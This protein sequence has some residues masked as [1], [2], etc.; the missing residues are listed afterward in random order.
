MSELPVLRFAPSPN[1]YLHLGHALSARVGRQLAQKLRGKFLVRIEDID[2]G[3]TREAFVSAIFEDLEWL[4][5][6]WDP[7]ILRQSQETPIYQRAAAHLHKLNLLYPCFATRS[8]IAITATAG[9]RD[10]QRDPDGAIV[11]PGLHRGMQQQEVERRITAGEQPAMRIRMDAAM[12]LATKRL[13]GRP[14]T[15]RELHPNGEIE[16]IEAQPHRWG[17]A[18]IQRKDFPASY[19]LAV[20]VDDARQGITHV[21][22]GQ[23]LFAATDIHRLLQVLLDLPEPI[24]HHHRLLV[25]ANGNKL[26]KSSGARSLRDLRNTGWTP[27]QVLE[28]IND[29]HQN[30]RDFP[31]SSR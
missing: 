17:D 27:A 30:S 25:D 22:R 23:D 28:A 4:G 3:R 16:T 11:Y 1:G 19:H 14:L 6:T 7:R 31:V 12:E 29:T 2:Q 13:G 8:E 9:G 15:F 26:S 21:T 5:L 18:I 10:P 20:V 24:Y